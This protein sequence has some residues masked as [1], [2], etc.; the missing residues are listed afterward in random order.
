[1]FYGGC[2]FC[3]KC[4]DCEMEGKPAEDCHIEALNKAVADF[5]AE[6]AKILDGYVAKV[7]QILKSFHIIS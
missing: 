2:M 4:V 6:M 1:M 7:E 5:K 3:N